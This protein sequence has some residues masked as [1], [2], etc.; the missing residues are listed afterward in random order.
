MNNIDLRLERQSPRMIKLQKALESTNDVEGKL[1][2]LVK[3]YP[4]TRLIKL[5]DALK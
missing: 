3:R 2:K 5:S 4:L 1:V